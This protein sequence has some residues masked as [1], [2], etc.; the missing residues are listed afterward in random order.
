[1]HP[2]LSASITPTLTLNIINHMKLHVNRLKRKK[3]EDRKEEERKK[4]RKSK[5]S[6]EAISGLKK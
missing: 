6:A 4:T 1:M 5:E 3:V 2:I